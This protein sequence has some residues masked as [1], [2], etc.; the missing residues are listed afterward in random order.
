MMYGY[1]FDPQDWLF[2]LVM[3]VMVVSMVVVMMRGF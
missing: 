2:M 3:M 1:D